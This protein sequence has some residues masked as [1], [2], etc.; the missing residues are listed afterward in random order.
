VPRSSSEVPCTTWRM[1]TAI[2]LHVINTAHDQ[3]IAVICCNDEMHSIC[4]DIPSRCHHLPVIHD[5]GQVTMISIHYPRTCSSSCTAAPLIG[6]AHACWCGVWCQVSHCG[7][8]VSERNPTSHLASRHPSCVC[9]SC[10]TLCQRCLNAK[11]AH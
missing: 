5:R 4:N 11:V 6:N 1:A 10:V 2:S 8:R 3:V 7:L 9:Y